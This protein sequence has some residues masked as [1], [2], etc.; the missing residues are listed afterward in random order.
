M[1]SR[2][3]SFPSAVVVAGMP[4]HS[5]LTYSASYLRLTA[6]QQRRIKATLPVQRTSGVEP[7]AA[8]GTSTS[9]HGYARN[10]IGVDRSVYV[11]N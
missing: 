2:P 8:A 7:T 4:F 1:D 10:G 5:F 11:A 3:G 9:G 6:E